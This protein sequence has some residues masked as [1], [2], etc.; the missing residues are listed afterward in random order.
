[1]RENFSP[2]FK[3]D[4]EFHERFLVKSLMEIRPVVSHSDTCEQT[5]GHDETNR[6][7]GDCAKEL[8]KR[9]MD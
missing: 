1:V 4:L 7:L 8:K 3:T 5:D 9:G 2:I 6:H